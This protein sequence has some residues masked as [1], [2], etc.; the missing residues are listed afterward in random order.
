MARLILE[1]GVRAG[2]VCGLKPEHIDFKNKAILIEN[3]KNNQ[4]RYVYFGQ[5]MS[6][7]LKRWMQ[8][9]DRYSGSEYLFPT[10]RGTQ[11]DIRNFEY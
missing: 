6:T 7:D 1:T 5:K 8:Y 9:R 4:Q 11:L 3:P 10:I 2:E